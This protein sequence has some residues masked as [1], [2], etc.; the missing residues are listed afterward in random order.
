LFLFLFSIIGIEVARRKYYSSHRKNVKGKVVLI[1]GGASG[2]GRQMALRFAR[3]GSVVVIWD[4]NKEG[5]AKV[6][7]E[8][9]KE[10]GQVFSYVV[11]LSKREQIYKVAE[12]VKQK[13]ERVDILINNAGIVTGKSILDVKDEL[14]QL[15]IDVNTTAHFWT[16]KAFLP[17]M[18]DNEE[19][20]IVTIAS[21]AGI[22][23]VR[24][25]ADYCASKFGAL[26]FD[27][28]LRM[29]FR[30]RKGKFYTT[31]ICPYYINTG[32]FKGC[33]TRFPWLLPILEEDY[34]A[35]QIVN[36]IRENRPFLALPAIVHY[37]LL[38]AKAAL[39]VGIFD[40]AADFLGANHS[41]DDFVGRNEDKKGK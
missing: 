37:V 34:V 24:G 3:L 31:C 23:G 38:L 39:P 12:E 33:K 26:G 22:M 17:G 29:D 19:G 40:W 4:I 11:D 10:K 5:L 13:F 25:L 30:H 21:A 20:H 15:T 16:V 28:S 27:E 32:M 9:V 7:E 36:A 18:I 14:A 2:I 1:T 35:D 41:M 6:E 8:I